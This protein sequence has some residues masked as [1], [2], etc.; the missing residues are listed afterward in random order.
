MFGLSFSKIMALVGVILAVWA[1]Y[2]WINRA[3]AARSVREREPA[4]RPE[5]IPTEDLVPCPGCGAYV[6]ARSPRGCGRSG[7]PYPG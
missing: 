4:R 3:Q 1:V 5:A 6:P 2:K 7:C